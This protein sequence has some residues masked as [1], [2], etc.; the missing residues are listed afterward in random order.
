MNL[1][2]FVSYVLYYLEIFYFLSVALDKTYASNTSHGCTLL[3]DMNDARYNLLVLKTD[4]LEYFTVLASN[5]SVA[6]P[7]KLSIYPPSSN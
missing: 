6:H 4:I 7:F 3:V 1:H 5:T 2:Q